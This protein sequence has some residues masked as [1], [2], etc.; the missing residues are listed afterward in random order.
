M[1]KI[2]GTWYFNETL[3]DVNLANQSISFISEAK[4]YIGML[5]SERKE[6]LRY[7]NKGGGEGGVYGDADGSWRN[8]AYR[9]VD[10]GAAYQEVSDEFYNWL[11]ANAEQIT[12]VK[13]VTVRNK[14]AT[15][16]VNEDGAMVCGNLYKIVFEFDEEWDS[17]TNKTARLIYG[18]GFKDIPFTG[19]EVELPMFFGV[20]KV[21]IGVFVGDDYATTEATIPCYPSCLCNKDEKFRILEEYDGAYER[22][23]PTVSGVW[24]FNETIKPTDN[25]VNTDTSIGSY[26]NF[27]F[28]GNAYIYLWSDYCE[29]SAQ[30]FK[31]EESIS[32]GECD[33]EFIGGEALDFGTEP[34]EVSEEFYAWL[35]ANA[36]RG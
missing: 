6:E 1:A 10:F 29:N 36:V 18:G 11:I 28:G 25:M 5:Y 31:S 35:T 8:E 17:I 19:N 7:S 12:S 16:S 24:V 30:G 34:Q 4:E 15:Y 13:Y 21:N 20:T 33:V 14:I 9:T 22:L 32:A 23:V 27:T 3:T 2:R 26:I